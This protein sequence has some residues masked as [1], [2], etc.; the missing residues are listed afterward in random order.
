M[1]VSQLSAPALYTTKVYWGYLYRDNGKENGNHYHYNRVYGS[2][3]LYRDN[4]K[5]N[6][7]YY[8]NII[9]YMGLRGSVG[10]IK[11]KLL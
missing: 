8:N 1:E 5:E 7:N 6:G 11:W 9:G 3:G 4:G 10:I 2:K